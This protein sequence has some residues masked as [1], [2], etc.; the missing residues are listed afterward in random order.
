MDFPV[1]NKLLE[2]SALSVCRVKS[3]GDQRREIKHSHRRQLPS[4]A[5]GSG[6]REV[7]QISLS[8]PHLQA[9]SVSAQNRASSSCCRVKWEL[10]LLM[11]QAAHDIK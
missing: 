7:L 1:C 3:D 5:T 6:T 9:N 11:A 8:P 4:H 2:F 10:D